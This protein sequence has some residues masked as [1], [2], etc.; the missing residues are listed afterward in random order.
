[1]KKFIISIFIFFLLGTNS[2]F[3]LDANSSLSCYG[4]QLLGRVEN[5]TLIDE[6][7]S[8]AA[9]LDTGAAMSSLSATRI[10]PQKKNNKI[11]IK[12]TFVEPNTQK[13]Y[14][15]EKPLVRYMKI[16][17]RK[18]ESQKQKYSLRPVVAL[19]ILI[20][21]QKQFILVNLIDRSDFQY[22]MLLGADSLKKLHI[23]VDVSQE[24]LEHLEH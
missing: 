14:I 2:T 1:M 20:G 24:H 3:S 18:E 10:E 19:P 12:F 5:I 7:I 22:P 6:N 17:N 8:I 11:Y 15:F 23:I 9:K 13:K 4:K 21:N 16:L